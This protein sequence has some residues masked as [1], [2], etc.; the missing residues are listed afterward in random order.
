M[1]TFSVLLNAYTSLGYWD[2]CQTIV[3]NLA[4]TME[5]TLLGS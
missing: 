3:G 2:E 1:P 5:H 4:S